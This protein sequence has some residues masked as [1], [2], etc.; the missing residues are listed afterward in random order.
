MTLPPTSRIVATA[1]S[2]VVVLAGGF[3]VLR[4]PRGAPPPSAAATLASR[5]R[6]LQARVAL[7][8]EDRLYLLLDPAHGS[9]G[10][11]RGGAALVSWPVS[12]VE[13]GRRRLWP[14]RGRADWRSSLWEGARLEPPVRRE[15]RVIA[16]DQ[17]EPPDPTGEVE[18]VPPT[19]EEEIP[20]PERFFIHFEGGLGVEVTA[21]GAD[22]LPHRPGL[23]QRVRTGLTRMS[24]VN[25]DRYRIRLSMQP[26]DA[27]ALYRGLPASV[28]F[29]AVLP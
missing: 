4:D 26:G 18:W 23:G 9:L 10:L 12:A 6:A 13:A 14:G 29:L 19:P 20:T 3:L 5:E 2:L 17:A 16:S 25:W 8:A 1:A 22:T 24:P 28:A 11:Y 15:R 27:G 21:P 7:A